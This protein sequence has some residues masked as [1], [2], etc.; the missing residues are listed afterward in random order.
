MRIQREEKI[1]FTAAQG[2]SGERGGQVQIRGRA[3][4]PALLPAPRTSGRT[5]HVRGFSSWNV[6]QLGF[7]LWKKPCDRLSAI[8]GDASPGFYCPGWQ[9][10]REGEG[11]G[12]CRQLLR[13]LQDGAVSPAQRALLGCSALGW[14]FWGEPKRGTPSQPPSSARGRGSAALGSRARSRRSI[15][16]SRS[17]QGLWAPRSPP[18]LRALQHPPHPGGWKTSL[19]LQTPRLAGRP[20]KSLSLIFLPLPDSTYRL[21]GDFFHRH[22]HPWMPGRSAGG[23]LGTGKEFR[24]APWG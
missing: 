9:Q 17:S 12:N 7:L 14:G 16:C 15:L 1:Q 11:E 6:L 2:C 18:S 24:A 8:P 13:G 10:A 5:Q 22:H 4:H 21:G 23:G 20:K 19:L 3:A